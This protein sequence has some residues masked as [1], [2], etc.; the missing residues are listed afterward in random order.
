MT[1]KLKSL[2]DEFPEI[3]KQWHPTRNNNLSPSEVLFRTVKKVWWK[4]DE[5]H[6]WEA[7]VRSRIRG[8]SCPEC[9]RIKRKQ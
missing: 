5:G 6:E 4:C 2:Q 9:Y 8:T 3:A 7:G 1:L